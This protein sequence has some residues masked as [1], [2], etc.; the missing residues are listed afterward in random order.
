MITFGVNGRST[1][2]IEAA[3]R[4]PAVQQHAD[5]IA[6]IRKG[7]KLNEGRRVPESTLTIIMGRMSCYTG[8]IINWEWIMNES[9]LDL[10]PPEYA[11][12]EL[13]IRPEPEPG[14]SKLL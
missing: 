10:S 5:Q 1:V 2:E 6:A 13:Q 3:D 7:Q 12:G 14:M 4:N 8:Q 9:N 11:F